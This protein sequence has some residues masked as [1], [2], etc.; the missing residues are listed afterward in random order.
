MLKD[1][2][3]SED[4]FVKGVFEARIEEGLLGEAASEMK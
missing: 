4:D 1:K 3:V 2:G